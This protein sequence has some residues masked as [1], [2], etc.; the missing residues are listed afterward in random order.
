MDDKRL[1]IANLRFLR[2]RAGL[3]AQELADMAGCN[4]QTI[5][6]IETDKRGKV[7]LHVA[8]SL[9]KALD[10]ETAELT[11]P[12]EE[13]EGYDNRALNAFLAADAAA[14]AELQ[15]YGPWGFEE[16]VAVASMFA[17]RYCYGMSVQMDDSD[18][19]EP[20]DRREVALDLWA[21]VKIMTD[22]IIDDHFP[23]D[24]QH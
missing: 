1:A 21:M 10:I 19:D 22:K 3:T 4:L 8:E 5:Q 24:C 9:A 12:D 2:V 16:G 11:G 15:K 7:Q 14:E 18:S 13:C 6:E 17:A 20:I 23:P